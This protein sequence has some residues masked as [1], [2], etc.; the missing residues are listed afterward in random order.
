MRGTGIGDLKDLEAESSDEEA[1]FP[2]ANSDSAK[3]FVRSFLLTIVVIFIVQ[4]WLHYQR[5]FE[6]ML[7]YYWLVA[8]VFVDYP[9]FY[10]A[11][12]TVS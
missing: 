3:K 8:V 7:L 2:A 4:H 6:T 10:S 12:S 11:F 9:H 1:E 5:S